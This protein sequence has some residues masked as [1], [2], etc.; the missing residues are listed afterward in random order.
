LI[1][2][3]LIIEVVAWQQDKEEDGK[4]GSASYLEESWYYL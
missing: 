1:G 2:L 4:K 3:K